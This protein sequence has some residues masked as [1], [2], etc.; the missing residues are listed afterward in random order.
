DPDPLLARVG[1]VDL[2]LLAVV[3]AAGR[4]PG[5]VTEGVGLLDVE[6][7][8]EVAGVPAVHLR[9]GGDPEPGEPAEEGGGDGGRGETRAQIAAEEGAEAREERT[10]RAARGARTV[11]RGWGEGLL[12]HDNYRL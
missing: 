7:D 2:V 10:A 8:P 3:E 6:G 4:L 9:E 12:G 11:T 1:A 5:A